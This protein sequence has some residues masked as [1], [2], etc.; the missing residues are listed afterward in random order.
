MEFE[1]G[2]EAKDSLIGPFA[3]A[4]QRM[5]S[6][7]SLKGQGKSTIVLIHHRK[8]WKQ[9]VNKRTINL[10]L[11]EKSIISIMVVAMDLMLMVGTTTEME[12]TLLKKIMDLVTSLLMLNLMGTLL[13]MIMGKLKERVRLF[14]QEKK[15]K[16]IMKAKRCEDK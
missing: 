15:E 16:K 14:D 1:I 6:L 11:Q 4:M 2:Q 8:G 12:T 5:V 3:S 13:M 10:R 9:R 7:K